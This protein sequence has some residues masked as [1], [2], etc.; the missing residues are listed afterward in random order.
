MK[1]KTSR[2]VPAIAG[3]PNRDIPA[4]SDHVQAITDDLTNAITGGLLVNDANLPFSL[5][6]KN[7]T[8]DVPFE[9][10]GYGATIV[11]SSSKVVGFKTKILKQGLLQVSITIENGGK[12]DCALLLI[13]E[14]IKG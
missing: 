14:A 5:Y 3:D 8:S 4:L 2:K 12:S 10:T 6:K 7:I 1:T 9:V 13:N 11:Y